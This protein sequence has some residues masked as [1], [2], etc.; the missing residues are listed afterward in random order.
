MLMFSSYNQK[1]FAVRHI[2][3]PVNPSSDHFHTDAV[4]S[5]SVHCRTGIV[6]PPSDRDCIATVA[7]SSDVY[8]IDIV[9][10]SSVHCDTDTVPPY[11]DHYGT[12]KVVRPSDH[13]HTTRTNNVNVLEKKTFTNSLDLTDGPRAVPPPL[14]TPRHPTQDQRRELSN[15]PTS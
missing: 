12:K 9:V 8:C 6:L 15:V 13:L 4:A 1:C 5:S 11:S 2:H 10:P 14:A 3:Y 7:P